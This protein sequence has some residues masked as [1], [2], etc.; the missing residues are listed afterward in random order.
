[1]KRENMKREEIKRKPCIGVLF[2]GKSGEH[3]ISLSSAASVIEAIDLGRY[4]VFPIAISREGEWFPGREAIGRLGGQISS[5]R[6][7]A[8]RAQLAQSAWDEKRSAE[9]ETTA[10]AGGLPE[11]WR[12]APSR[13]GVVDSIFSVPWER[14][15][16]LFPV[17]HGPYGE[18]GTIQGFLEVMGIPYVGS[19]ILASAVAMDKVFSKRI[20][21][22]AG[23][24]QVR[25]QAY[26]EDYFLA[27]RGSIIQEIE[28]AL[29]FP[30]FVKPANLGSSVGIS[31]V[32]T[33]EELVKALQLAFQYDAK[34]IVE[35]AVT[36]LDIEVAVLGNQGSH[37]QTTLAGEIVPTHDFYDYTAKYITP[38]Q[39]RIPAGLSEEEQQQI[40]QLA[41][42]AYQAV[43]CDGLAR[44]DFFLQKETR[45]LFVNEINTMPGF[46]PHSMFA[47][48]WEQSGLSYPS[49]IDRLITL[50][51]QRATQRAKKDAS[52]SSFCTAAGA[53]GAPQG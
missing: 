12:G 51:L 6:R 50:G 17:L 19:G 10:G 24:P 28:E 16:I 11:G 25:Y 27:Y 32:S 44:V 22:A 39:V 36:A 45:R 46:T 20:F 23:L 42:R 15:D 43:E 7:E 5:A 29:G 4:G 30:C 52:S 47:K 21:A 2:G 13:G 35:E 9:E 37:P 1:M 14:L 18:D 26:R 8:L 49:L 48:L 3:E 40:Q 34:T 53:P 31:K 41:V 33:K 38:S